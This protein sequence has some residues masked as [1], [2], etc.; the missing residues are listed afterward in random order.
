LDRKARNETPPVWFG[1]LFVVIGLSVLLVAVG[2]IPADPASV[3]APP[4][5][6]GSV[7]VVFT[8]GGVMTFTMQMDPWINDLLAILLIGCMAAISSWVAFGPGERQFSG[9]VSVGPVGVGASGAPSMG[10]I[11]FGVGSVL[12]WA[13]VF[14]LIHR[15]VKGTRQTT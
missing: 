5:V 13:M 12:L 8:L 4:W 9:G 14:F 10:R 3:H 15:Y 11:V 6:L 7:G 2:V 1:A